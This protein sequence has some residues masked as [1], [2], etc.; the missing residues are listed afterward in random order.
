[1]RIGPCFLLFALDGLTLLACSSPGAG[2]TTD[3]SRADS[4]ILPFRVDA[5]A[6]GE[7]HE[8]FGFDAAPLLGRW[9]REIA[10]QSPGPGEV[11]LH[12]ATL[13]AVPADYPDGPVPVRLDARVVDHACLGSGR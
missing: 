6:N 5:P 8:C 2:R 10:W 7:A 3:A 4:L 13:Y 11:E 1:M 12:H 9:L